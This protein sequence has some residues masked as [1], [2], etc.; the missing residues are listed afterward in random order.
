MCERENSM[1]KKIVIGVLLGLLFLG[2]TIGILQKEKG[3]VVNES[4]V[5][6][7]QPEEVPEEVTVKS[8]SKVL[9]AQEFE[10]LNDDMRDQEQGTSI[11]KGGEAGK[12]KE[13]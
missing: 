11:G 4:V 8:S 1:K 9:N 2:I 7:A 10:N 3:T 5:E 6:T 13:S 12:A